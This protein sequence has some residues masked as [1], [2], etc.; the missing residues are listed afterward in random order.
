MDPADKPPFTFIK[1]T[2]NLTHYENNPTQR[3]EIQIF[4]RNGSFFESRKT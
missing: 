1:P 4:E 2:L 3:L